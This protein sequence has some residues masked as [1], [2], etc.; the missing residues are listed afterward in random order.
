[1]TELAITI[2]TCAWEP[3]DAQLRVANYLAAGYTQQ[4][5]A[6]AC[7]VPLR[8]LGDWLHDTPMRE[9]VHDLQAEL[10]D[11]Q[12]PQFQK[13]MD[14]AQRVVLQAL[15]G[16][17]AADDPVVLLA[18]RV[19][20]RTLHRIVTMEARGSGRNVPT[21]PQRLPYAAGTEPA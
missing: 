10:R 2:P 21:E 14:L 5:A 20:A 4:R 15:A 1:M 18:E 9:L 16:E 11:T 19:L 3:T 6:T 7:K 8:T 17:C 12:E 13:T